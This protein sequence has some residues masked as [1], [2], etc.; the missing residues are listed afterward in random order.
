MGFGVPIGAWLRGELREMA[1]DI[2]LDRRATARGYFRPQAVRG[3]LD[4]HSAG[5]AH[6]HT[7]IWALLMLELWHR[8]W[9]DDEP[10]LA[11]PGKPSVD[12]RH[13]TAT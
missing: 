2:L 11:P 9:V 6:R 3:Y 7:Q 5:R 13:V 8:M 10:P 4:D 1:Y 12:E